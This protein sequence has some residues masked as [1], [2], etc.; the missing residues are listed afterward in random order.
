MPVHGAMTLTMAAPVANGISLSQ[1]PSA[2]GLQSLVLNGALVTGGV[3]VLDVP[4][5]VAI[6]STGNEI[7]LTFVIT[8]T[9]FAGR[10]QSESLA[11]PNTTTVASALYYQ[12]VTSITVSGNTAGNITVGTNGQATT[13][14][15]PMN[16]NRYPVSSQICNISAGGSLTYTV[17]FTGDDLQI[18]NGVVNPNASVTAIAQNHTTLTSQ[19]VN[20]TGI[21]ISGVCGVRLVTNAW[22]SGSVT[23]NVIQ[24]S[25]TAG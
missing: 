11:G 16:Y 8:G 9:N 19:T 14:W 24:S 5:K 22:S 2:G 15:F 10:P 7:A 25:A 6:T 20:N 17:Q 1:K 23:M 4:R 3:A 18:T 12:T 13:P 21:L